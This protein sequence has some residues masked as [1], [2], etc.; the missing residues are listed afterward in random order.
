MAEFQQVL[1]NILYIVLTAIL[2]IVVTYGIK[3]LKA[4]IN[5]CNAI[6]DATQSEELSNY[7][8]DAMCNVMDAVVYVNQT[9]VDSLKKSGKFDEDAQ[10]EAFNKAFAHAA[11]LLSEGSNKAIQALHGSVE[12]WLTIQ[13]EAAVKAAKK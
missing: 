10:K 4:K 12:N 5:E 6:K 8:K 3:F 2:P 9:Y 11:C 13:I 7:V 1:N